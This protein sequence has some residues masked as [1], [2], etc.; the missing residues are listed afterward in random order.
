MSTAPAR[1]EERRPSKTRAAGVSIASNAALIALKIA[2]AAITGSV[3]IASE[4]IHSA[5]DLLA[6]IVAFVSVRKADEPADDTH[7]YGHQKAENL[8]AAIEGMLIL[9]G[10]GVIVYEAVSRL[11]SGAQVASVGVGIAV[12]AFS[13]AV[14]LG[15]GAFVRRRARQTD[16]AALEGDAAHIASDAVTSAGVLAGL[17]LVKLTG[18]DWIDSAVA[19]VVA[20]WIVASGLRILT[21]SSRVLLDETLPADEL[22]AI[23][24]EVVAFGDRGVAGFHQLRARRAGAHRYVDLHVQF[25]A[26]TTLEDAH[27][28]AHELQDA[29]RGQLGGA[30]VLIHL[31]PEDRVR[32][33]TEI[34][35]APGPERPPVSAG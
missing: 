24:R 31:E 9:V 30:A 26:G 35:P 3:A 16:S 27:R 28:T 34:L 32:P 2:A 22:D 29:I 18:A 7:H 12:I 10:S 11:V 6:S 13:L 23:R 5:I 15:V 20:V 25:R 21:R 19:L 8:A 33:G 17:V 1:P 4:A 14:N